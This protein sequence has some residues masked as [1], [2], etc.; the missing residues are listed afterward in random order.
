M[1]LKRKKEIVQ[2]ARSLP[3]Y[4]NRCPTIRAAKIRLSQGSMIAATPTGPTDHRLFFQRPRAMRECAIRRAKP[5]DRSSETALFRYR[6]STLDAQ[7][8]PPEEKA[9]ETGRC[10]RARDFTA[11][12]GCQSPSEIEGGRGPRPRVAGPCSRGGRRQPAQTLP[13]RPERASG[14]DCARRPVSGSRGTEGA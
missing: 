10:E 5:L 2:P 9:R 12:G 4:L 13:K 11:S 1:K 7:V 6:C 14:I 3:A 8:E